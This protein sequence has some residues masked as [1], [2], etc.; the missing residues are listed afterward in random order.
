MC[1]ACWTTSRFWVV[2]QMLPCEQ[3]GKYLRY[4]PRYGAGEATS[5]TVQQAKC[6]LFAYS[7]GENDGAEISVDRFDCGS[8]NE[9][10]VPES[11]K[12]KFKNADANR[13]TRH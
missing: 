6:V 10:D 1:E 9:I 7:F 4:H 2:I 11:G 5:P 3:L 8:I 12:D 13:T